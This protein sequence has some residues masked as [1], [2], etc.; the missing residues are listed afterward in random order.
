[1]ILR[2]L[3]LRLEPVQDSHFEGLRAL[4]SDPAAMRFLGGPK[5]DDEVRA[6]ISAAQGH[7]ARVGFNWWSVIEQGNEELLGAVSTQHI[8]ND[9]TKPIEIGWRFRSEHWGKGYATEAGRAMLRF[10]FD[11]VGVREVYAV[12]KPENQAS[13]RVMERLDMRYAGLRSFYGNMCATYVKGRD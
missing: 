6:W 3:R 2:T 7:W 1:M 13:L 12:A 10:A 11:E 5:T 9:E 4:H 8:E